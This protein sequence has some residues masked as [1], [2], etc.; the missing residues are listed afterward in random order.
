MIKHGTLDVGCGK[1]SYS[2][3]G[4][5]PAPADCWQQ[6]WDYFPMYLVSNTQGWLNNGGDTF[7]KH[8]EDKCGWLTTTNGNWV[9]EDGP[10]N[11]VVKFLLAHK[12]HA[13]VEEGVRLAGA[14]EVACIDRVYI[15]EEGKMMWP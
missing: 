13:C 3:E 10:P 8:I 4:P 12:N 9:T 14:R 5:P 15:N 11:T 6:N 1:Y 2:L 7:K